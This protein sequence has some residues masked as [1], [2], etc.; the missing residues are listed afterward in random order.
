MAR[1]L[2]IDLGTANTL[3]YMKGR[4]IVYNEPSVIALNKQTGE[5]LGTVDIGA[6]FGDTF[7]KAMKARFGVEVAIHQLNGDAVKTLASTRAGTLPA[8]DLVQRVLGG[9]CAHERMPQ[10]GVRIYDDAILR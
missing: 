2:A 6:S 3:V 5:V 9:S 1:D 7:V 10:L 8:K 4:G